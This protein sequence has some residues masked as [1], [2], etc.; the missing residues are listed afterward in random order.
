MFFF[1]KFFHKREEK[2]QDEMKMIRQIVKN[3]V[4][5]HIT[6]MLLLFLYE[7]D[8]QMLIL[9]VLNEGFSAMV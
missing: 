7:D 1:I 3:L 4:Q 6:T 2:M 8:F 5:I 9:C